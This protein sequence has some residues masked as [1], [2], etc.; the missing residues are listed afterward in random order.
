MQSPPVIMPLGGSNTADYLGLNTRYF[1]TFMERGGF[2][3]EAHSIH[4]I[5]QENQYQTILGTKNL[6]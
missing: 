2:S 1:G 4:D 3:R 5:Q 6:K